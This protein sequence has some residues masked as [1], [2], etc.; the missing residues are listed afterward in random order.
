MGTVCLQAGTADPAEVRGTT[1]GAAGGFGDA[2]CLRCPWNLERDLEI[3]SLPHQ[4]C[5]AHLRWLQLA[6]LD[7]LKCRDAGPS[8]LM[9][10]MHM[11]APK[12][13]HA[14]YLSIT[15]QNYA[16]VHEVE[17]SKNAHIQN[18]MLNHEKVRMAPPKQSTE[19]CEG[20]GAH[21]WDQRY[22]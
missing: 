5:S 4:L 19:H 6:S 3:G 12:Y 16:E 22:D 17:E 7:T 10:D 18:L 21:A 13:Q 1:Q 9:C 20:G 8:A 15:V 11:T 2:L 14:C